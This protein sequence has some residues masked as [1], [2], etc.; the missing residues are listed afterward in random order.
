[1]LNP[2]AM[3]PVLVAE[4]FP[5]VPGAAVI[6]EFLDEIGGGSWGITG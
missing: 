6:A 5:P 2:A 3:T 4:G 1:M